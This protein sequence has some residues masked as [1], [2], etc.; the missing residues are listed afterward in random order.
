M[1]N[2]ISLA[3]C[4]SGETLKEM[5]DFKAF[6][7]F[8]I[9]RSELLNYH[10]NAI[11]FSIVLVSRG[12]VEDTLDPIQAALGAVISLAV[13]TPRKVT[14]CLAH[15]LAA[16]GEL[17][18]LG[19]LEQSGGHCCHVAEGVEVRVARVDEEWAG[20][21][22]FG[23]ALE[24]HAIR[25]VKLLLAGAL[26]RIVD[27]VDGALPQLSRGL[28]SSAPEVVLAVFRI[29]EE[30]L[31]GAV[32]IRRCCLALCGL[33]IAARVGFRVTEVI[34]RL[35]GQCAELLNITVAEDRSGAGGAL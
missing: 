2:F 6:K 26:Q 11:P 3:I 21:C 28:G 15:K 5:L 12:A 27:I 14:L 17:L 18:I 25:G 35:T 22:I 1:K 19:A 9:S 29:G 31:L 30:A 4:I 10:F 7:T 33:D 24:G 23:S 16:A 32:E 20:L 13:V 8:Q 34:R